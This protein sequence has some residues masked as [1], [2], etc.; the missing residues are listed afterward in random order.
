MVVEP[1]GRG[2]FGTIYKAQYYGEGDFRKFVAL[3]LLN[4][5]V[6]GIPDVVGRLRD[7][8]RILGLL[9]HR[10]IVNVDRLAQFNDRWAVVMEYVEGVDLSRLVSQGPVPAVT[11]L[12][13]TAE[14]ASALHAAWTTRHPDGYPIKLMH[15][16]IKPA[17]IQLTAHGEVKVLDF[18]IAR[19]VFSGREADTRTGVPGT[20]LYM[21][22]ERME[23][24]EGPESDVYSLGCVLFELLTGQRLGRTSPRPERHEAVLRSAEERLLRLR[25]TANLVDFV[26]TMLAYE[27]ED[28]PT[29]EQCVEIATLLRSNARGEPLRTWSARIVPPLVA[30]R[31]SLPPDNLAGQELLEQTTTSPP[32]MVPSLESVSAPTLAPQA[33]R[34]PPSVQDAEEER[35][36]HRS[37]LVFAL[38]IALGI[39]VTGGVLVG[40]VKG[41]HR[42]SPA[43]A[44]EQEPAPAPTEPL[45]PEPSPLQAEPAPAQEPV[46]AQE[47]AAKK[48]PKAQT[49]KPKAESQAGRAG[50]APAASEQTAAGPEHISVVVRLDGV[51]TAAF[52]LVDT[53]TGLSIP[54]R[55]GWAPPGTYSVMVECSGTGLKPA[56]VL[57][58]RSGETTRELS[59]NPLKCTCK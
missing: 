31:P 58:L 51:T 22:P 32:L 1:L 27:P 35:E 15:R 50:T 17:N 36:E 53:T 12:E 7:E 20:L 57:K 2:G 49:S 9:R 40:L 14:V 43:P 46:P 11:A 4:A 48:T 6:S 54:G 39:A 45:A 55:R 21:A 34:S 23:L 47:P 25:C 10:A 24:I 59:C 5:E 38:L 41:L 30:S 37:P 28:R 42:P 26:L 16:D 18:G 56:Y 3:K 52:S 29:A 44:V 33:P 13:I 19:A 8:A